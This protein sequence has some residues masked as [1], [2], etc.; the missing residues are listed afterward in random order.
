MSIPT[1]INDLSTTDAI[2]SPQGGDPVGGNVDDYFRSH[3][4]ITARQFKKGAD[5]APDATG[6][7]PMPMDGTYFNVTGTAA[8]SAIAPCFDGKI[9]VLRFTASL[10]L[11]NSAS[12][13]LPGGANIVTQ[14]EDYA[15]F[16]NDSG[17]TWRCLSYP[18]L[19]PK[20]TE[21]QWY[22][23]AVGE[24]L[25]LR[26]DVAGISAP[27]TDSLD[28]RYVKLTAGDA[29]NTGVLINESV[30]GS[31]A[32]VSATAVVSLAGS[33]FNG[34]T[35]NLLNT[36]R[37]YV[38]PGSAG[39][40]EESSNLSHAHGAS[41]DAQGYHA[42][43]VSDPGHGHV[44]GMDNASAAGLF[45]SIAANHGQSRQSTIFQDNNFTGIGI[46]AGG[47]HAH[48]IYVAADG[49]AESRPRSIGATYYLR[50]K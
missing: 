19:A 3:A 35:I 47:T 5:L 41:S 16:V 12:F 45:N 22:S 46:Q 43:G 34:L 49:G 50:I 2:N 37:R 7:L 27:P 4:G 36:E 25:V 28:Y 42:H 1:S 39:V 29:Y 11:T 9:A 20:K 21:T 24:V 30:S 6:S 10:T 15:I 23:K 31:G 44:T 33:P 48:N 38:R 17:T 13:I 14:A 26:D 40:T 8:V 18:R 32:T